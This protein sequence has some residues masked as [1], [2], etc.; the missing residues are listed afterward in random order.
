MPLVNAIIKESLRMYP[1]VIFTFRET[2]QDLDMCG[3]T[4][5]QG[6]QVVLHSYIYGRLPQ[7]WDKP[8]VFMPKR[9]LVDDSADKANPYRFLPFL[10]GCRQC[11]GN[12]FALYEAASI[13][14]TLILRL[15]FK[16]AEGHPE[17]Q[18]KQRITLRLHPKLEL[19]VS[20][21]K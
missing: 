11:V 5:P 20:R 18:P 4:I 13:L 10:I 7:W 21:A 12:R 9:W 1:P 3:Y 6:T 19:A 8:D 2:A 15:D 17:V 14:A 16:M